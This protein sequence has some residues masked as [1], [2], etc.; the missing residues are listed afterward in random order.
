[1]GRLEMEEWEQGLDN[2]RIG[3]KRMGTRKDWIMESDGLNNE[4]IGKRRMAESK[5]WIMRGGGG[6]GD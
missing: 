2:E 6:Q 1:M 3:K 4:R 5:D